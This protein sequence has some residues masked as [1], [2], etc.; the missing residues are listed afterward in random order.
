MLHGVTLGKKVVF[1]DHSLF[2]FSDAASININKVLKWVIADVDACICVSHINKDNLS[3]RAAIDPNIIYVIPN[4]VD[5]TRFQPDTSKRHPPNRINIVVVSRMMYRKGVDLLIDII[6]EIVRKHPEVYFIIGGDGDKLPLIH[7]MRDKYNLADRMEILGRVPHHKVRD[8]LCRGHIFLNTSL[9]EAFCIAILEAASCGLLCVSTNVGGVP[10]VL[11]PDMVY[12][13]PARPKP[14]IQQLERAIANYRNIPSQD[15]HER[16]KQLYSWRNVAQRVER[17]YENIH[18][19]P[20]PTLLGRIKNSLSLG[21][22]AGLLSA[23]W[24]ILELIVLV[25]WEWLTPECSIEQA[26]DFDHS[27]YMADKESFG[28][29]TFKVSQSKTDQKDSISS[30]EYYETYVTEEGKLRIRLK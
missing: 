25:F 6:P 26:V 13:A 14:M 29:H 20:R 19:T 3:L 1:T 16:I 23:L 22:I 17:V 28:D 11:P 9:T 30:N 8:V 27:R 15:F 7:A 4:A 10:E 5:T 18:T 24:L 21:L 2:G 12:L